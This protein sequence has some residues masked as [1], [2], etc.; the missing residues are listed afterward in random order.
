M[1]NGALWV[2]VL[3]AGTAV[4]ASWVTSKGNAQAARVQAQAT[5]EAAHDAREREARRATQLAFIQ[6]ANDMGILYRRIPKYLDVEDPEA[7]Q[8][9]L[10]EL[11]DQL[12]DCYGP[13]L[14]ALAVVSLECHPGPAAAANAV[15]GASGEAYA[16][17]AAAEND[18]REAEHFRRAADAY[19]A[20]IDVFVEAARRAEHAG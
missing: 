17:L 15:H 3:T 4:V 20:S 2:A 11:R 8:E 16:R 12:R 14:R 13:F 6:E 7:R 19:L 10:A 1:D 5:A 9:F 18:I